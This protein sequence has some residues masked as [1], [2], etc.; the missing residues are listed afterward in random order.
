[1]SELR[2]S[3]KDQADALRILD[4]LDAWVLECGIADLKA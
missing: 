2:E 4:Q 1:M 3:K